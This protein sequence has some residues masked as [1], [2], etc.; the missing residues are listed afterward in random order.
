MEAIG[1]RGEV[2]D[3]ETDPA[4]LKELGTGMMAVLA[5]GRELSGAE[6]LNVERPTPNAWSP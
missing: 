3:R 2:L 5:E 4:R 1:G 6:R